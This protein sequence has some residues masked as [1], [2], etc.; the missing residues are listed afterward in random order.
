M[1]FVLRVLDAQVLASRGHIYVA[2]VDVIGTAKNVICTS[3]ARIAQ[4]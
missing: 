2:A 1:N 3:V 4:V